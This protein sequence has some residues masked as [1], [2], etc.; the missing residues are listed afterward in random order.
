MS[1]PA[2]D[3]LEGLPL[4]TGRVAM[5]VLGGVKH[6]TLTLNH[7]WLWSGQNRLRDT[8]PRAH[9][10]AE[11]RRLLSEERWEEATQAANDAFGG[12]GGISGQPNRVDPYQP[13]GDLWLHF[14]H[15]PYH[16]YRRSLDLETGLGQV[17]YSAGGLGRVTRTYLAD[18]NRDALYVHV[19]T[20]K[21][22]FDGVVELSR[23]FDPECD[24]HS[25][26][27][28]GVLD[29]RGQILA[30]TAFAVQCR[31][32]TR[33]GEQRVL[34][35]GRLAITGAQEMLLAVNIGTS[36][37][38]ADPA[39]EA[40][41]ATPDLAG[42]A[43][44]VAAH[45]ETYRRG[46]GSFQLAVA[47]LPDFST[48]PTPERVARVKQG[49]D[50][51]ALLLLY[52]ELARHLMLCSSARADLPANL[53]GKWN[54]D[55]QPPWDCDYHHDINLQMCYW[56]AEPAGLTDCLEALFRHVERF[57][58]HARKAAQDLYGCRG[59]YYPLQTDAWG[60]AT[61]ESYGWAVWIGAAAWLAQHFWEHFQ[62]SQ[63]HEFLAQRAYPF[64]REVVAFYEDYLV[65][66]EQGTLQIMPSQSPENRFVGSGSRHPVSIGIS[67]AMDVQLAWEI[68]TTASAAARLLGVDTAD[69]ERWEAMR[70]KLPPLQVGS[71]GQLLEWDREFEEVE[72]GHRHMS[73]LYAL[74]PGE[75]IDP[76][77]TPELF[78]AARRSLEL[79]LENLGGHTG[80]SRAWT[81]CLFAR[82]GDGEA[83]YEHL[84]HLASD[85]VTGSLLD[86]HPPRIFQI[87]GNFGGAAAVLEML[88]QSRGGRLHLLPAL[89]AQWATG[90]AQGLR[91]RGGFVVD[92]QWAAGKLVQGRVQAT[93]DG[94]CE[95]LYRQQPLV[96]CDQTGAV[97]AHAD[98]EGRVRFTAQGGQVYDLAPRA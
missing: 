24:L 48:L 72:P 95:V 28:P 21:A 88:L 3:W 23:A 83:A 94:P 43:D 63:D 75:Q 79:R 87:E 52:F 65:E 66:D 11:V 49:E 18:L 38:Q 32:A 15:G 61:P 84:Q 5:M 39:A 60:R 73:H 97:V 76:E 1:Q 89:P 68:L 74:H 34:D 14:T 90:E 44:Q 86:L 93:V 77:Q 51:P 20:E 40:A 54:E 41:I 27:E 55:L 59:V 70:A 6:D 50:D 25:T 92:L 46:R 56:F 80:W 22:P 37:R 42:W 53:Q 4:G 78:A 10:L 64:L 69:Q 67:A 85:Y 29:L 7:E 12:P 13:A 47:D 45:S 96:V 19:S 71:R 16:D 62:F 31:V 57:V 9:L 33:G 17:Q 58:P 36:V 81:A 91:A 8:E 2:A 98:V 30:G 35:S 26:A 82:L